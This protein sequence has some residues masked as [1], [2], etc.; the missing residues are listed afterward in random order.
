MDQDRQRGLA[1]L[2]ALL[3]Q[4]EAA[5]GEYETQELGGATDADWPRWYAAYLW[6]RGVAALLPE[7]ATDE[8]L[9]GELAECDAAYQRQQPAEDWPDFYARHLLAGAN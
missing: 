5:H 3:A 9:A 2:A 8:R 6:Q 4:A 1:E 7:G